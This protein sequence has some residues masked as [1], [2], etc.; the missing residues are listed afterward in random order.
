MSLAL[1]KSGEVSRSH[2]TSGSAQKSKTSYS[3]L[4][5]GKGTIIS[6]STAKPIRQQMSHTFSAKVHAF[7]LKHVQRSPLHALTAS[8]KS[9]G[10][11]SPETV[12]ARTR[13]RSPKTVQKQFKRKTVS[14]STVTKGDLP[15]S[16]ELA[17]ELPSPWLLVKGPTPGVLAW[18]CL[19]S[20]LICARCTS[21]S[22]VVCPIEVG[23]FTILPI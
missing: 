8:L 16:M 9:T 14:A 2:A 23:G 12:Q 17:S 13:G 21:R 4:L 20:I 22:F 1:D 10:G 5:I 6:P 3:N 15:A 11:M 18:I 19:S 7:R